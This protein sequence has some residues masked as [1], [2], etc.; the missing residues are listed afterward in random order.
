MQGLQRLEAAPK[1]APILA[2]ERTLPR[3][4]HGVLGMQVGGPAP[5]SALP[6]RFLG[7]GELDEHLFLEPGR[8]GMPG[9]IIP[10]AIPTRFPVLLGLSRR[11]RLPQERLT[12]RMSAGARDLLGNPSFALRDGALGP[13]NRILPGRAAQGEDGARDSQGHLQRL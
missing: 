10:E 6:T 11:G 9:P 3:P 2:P 8:S 4:Q 7:P 13:A 12:P 5:N 1:G